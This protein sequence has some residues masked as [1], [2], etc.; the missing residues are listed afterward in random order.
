DSTG[1]NAGLATFGID[2]IGHSGQA[3]ATSKDR[4]PRGFNAAQGLA[5]GFSTQANNGAAG[6]EITASQALAYAGANDPDQDALVFQHVGQV[7][8]SQDTA[9]WT[10][11]VLIAN[12]TYTD[13]GSGLGFLTVDVHPGDQVQVLAPV[14]GG[15]WQ[16]PGNVLTAAVVPG[17]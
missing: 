8:G 13:N 1:D 12:G 16:G 9:T 4:A 7:A 5:S 10:Q 14:A 15:N 11:P 17:S 2:V 3:V 6:I